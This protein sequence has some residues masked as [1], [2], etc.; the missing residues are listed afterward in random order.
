[1]GVA[2]KRVKV[3][4]LIG[5][6]KIGG[7]ENSVV[8]LVNAMSY[9]PD[10]QVTPILY[11]RGT[12]LQSQLKP[13]L[14][15]VHP[16]A[17]SPTDNILNKFRRMVHL[18]TLLVQ[19]N[20]DCILSF[21]EV[22]NNFALLLGMGLNAKIII[23]DRGDFFYP[24]S[25]IHRSIRR[26]FYSMSDALF[27]QT[28]KQIARYQEFVE[29]ER[30][31]V[32]RNHF[33]AHKWERIQQLQNE[34]KRE[35]VLLTVGRFI[36]SKRIDLII[37]VF[38]L[39]GL[40]EKGYKLQ[41]VGDDDLGHKL[42]KSLEYLV[43]SL[44]LERYVEFL[45][46]REDVLD[47]M[48]KAQFFLFASVSEGMPN[49]L[50]ESLFAGCHVITSF[51][52]LDLQNLGIS[53]YSVCDTPESMALELIKN[54]TLREVGPEFKELLRKEFDVHHQYFKHLLD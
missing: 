34:V 23:A 14:V 32:V 39:S 44:D 7:T 25:L 54:E 31:H 19:E 29:K 51:D 36:P 10:I 47:L 13:K 33:P 18:R 3:F 30:I 45:G 48:C 27:I 21:G 26:V 46:F 38:K 35:S 28:N 2:G 42:K 17:L 52:Y 12:A 24:W 8:A 40:A 11:G 20:P 6:L 15:L 43:K 50:I 9:H 22:W 16:Q 37:R 1:M 4:F 5:S 49:V 53:T 41:I